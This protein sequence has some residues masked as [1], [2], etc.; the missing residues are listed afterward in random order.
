M[1]EMNIFPHWL[2]II[3][4]NLN[5]NND[6]YNHIREWNSVE[7]L[8]DTFDDGKGFTFTNF[9]GEPTFLTF[10]VRVGQK[11]LQVR[12]LALFLV[13][14]AATYLPR[15]MLL[16]KRKFPIA[17]EKEYK[18]CV[19]IILQ[20]GATTNKQRFNLKH[21]YLAYAKAKIIKKKSITPP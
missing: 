11:T 12:Y 15:F 19:Q 6:V 13:W 20:N 1:K 3:Y 21:P 2:K 9:L 17:K 4:L 18:A 10:T 5:P 7:K 16:T 8:A 14:L